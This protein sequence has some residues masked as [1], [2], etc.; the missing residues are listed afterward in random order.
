LHP[1]PAFQNIASDP[2]KAV[3][4]TGLNDLKDTFLPF[5]MSA[6]RARM[7][8]QARVKQGEEASASG[9]VVNGEKMGLFRTELDRIVRVLR[10]TVLNSLPSAAG[11]KQSSSTGPNLHAFRS[12]L[13]RRPSLQRSGPLIVLPALPLAPIELSRL[14]TCAWRGL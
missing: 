13:D 9:D 4:L 6:Q 12:P 14:G 2:K 7:L 11:G 5:M 8:E 1:L 3:V 10:D